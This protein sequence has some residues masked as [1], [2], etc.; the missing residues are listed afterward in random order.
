MIDSLHPLASRAYEVLREKIVEGALPA[1]SAFPDHSAMADELS[2][3]LLALWGA[4]ARLEDEGLIWNVPGRGVF[5]GGPPADAGLVGRQEELSALNRST[6]ALLAERTRALEE[7]RELRRANVEL[8][9]ASRVKSEFLATMSHE[10]RTPMNGV[11]GMTDLLLDTELTPEQREYADIARQS[12]EA[13]LTIINDILDFSKIEAG[14]LELEVADF[15]VRR[16]V[17]EV[18]ELLA[19]DARAKELELACLVYQDVPPVVRGDSARLRQI[20]INLIGNAVKFTEQGEVAVQGRLEGETAESVVLRFTVTDTGIGIAPEMQGRLFEVF[21]QQ[22]ASTTRRYG[23][24]GLGLAISKRLVELMG[25]EI[26]VESRV[27]VGT[28]FWFTVRLEQGAASG[29]IVSETP[30]NLT[31]VRVLIVD[32]N[33]TNRAI[34]KYQ[35][36]SWDMASATASSGPTALSLLRAGYERGKPFD[37]AILDM[38]MPGMD[39]LRLA[40]AIREDSELAATKLVMLASIRPRERGDEDDLALIDAYMTKPVRQAQLHAALLRLIGVRDVEEPKPPGA[41]GSSS[42]TP[43]Q[44]L[45]RVLVAEDDPVNQQVALR[46]LEKLGYRA[47]G[48]ANGQE[49]V[50]AL[51]LAS[52]DLLLMDCRMPVLDGYEA[53]REIR[54]RERGTD[55]HVPIIALTANAMKGDDRK[56]LAAGMDGYL[57]KPIQAERLRL[58]IQRWLSPAAGSTPAG[59]LDR[60]VLERWQRLREQGEPILLTE[61]ID[62]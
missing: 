55:R 31:G 21:S 46:M 19:A 27:D 24:T 44:A 14:R 36:A 6:Q 35:T 41:V 56:C 22:D 18:V 15:D 49:A 32:D 17:E 58:A 42:R 20:L 33:E 7:I 5:I 48:V 61:A 10:I 4:M 40:R 57:A 47:D 28:T 23:G 34:L 59:A 12:G 52:Y 50:M 37:V 1:G 13:L 30:V 2:V 43:R 29:F 9:R 45:G 54:I 26:G 3:P 11:I 62:S 38:E 8:E 16:T 53:A 25:G 39:G 60:A 51:Q